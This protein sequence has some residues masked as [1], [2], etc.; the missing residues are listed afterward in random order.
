M[1]FRAVR[2]KITL[3]P[4][5]CR[6]T[7]SNT[8]VVDKFLMRAVFAFVMA[9]SLLPVLL[10]AQQGAPPKDHPKIYTND[11]LEG[12]SGGISVVGEPS[13]PEKAAREKDEPRSLSPAKPK[14]KV[15]DK[16]EACADWAWGSAVAVALGAQGVPF[17]AAYWVDKT[18]GGTRCSKS[19]GGASS[20]T[21]SVD[22]DYALDDGRKV[23]ISSTIG[24]PGGSAMVAAAK[25]GR[26]M[27]VVWNGMAYIS[28]G[29]RYDKV[30]YSD[31]SVE[32]VLKE[33]D[34]VNPYLEQSL[35]FKGNP[36]EIEV[37]QFA[38]EARQ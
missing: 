33:I 16:K 29:I 37:V 30:T 12:K 32:F 36:R 19:V 17:D 4:A 18:F 21:S 35:T 3:M 5:A 6:P 10:H 20:L 31:G 7:V 14:A 9:V 34:L 1:A 15:P 38:V 2:A 23:R 13:K 24:L 28:S 27:V 25:Q 11:D 22:G 26:P 8:A